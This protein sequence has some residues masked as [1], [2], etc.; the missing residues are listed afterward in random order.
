MSKD[1]GTLD[2]DAERINFENACPDQLETLDEALAQMQD[3]SDRFDDACS[4][5]PEERTEDQADLA[6]ASGC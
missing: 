3:T 1:E 4:T 5:P 2:A 6:E